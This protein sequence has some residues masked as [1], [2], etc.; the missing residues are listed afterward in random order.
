MKIGVLALQGAVAEHIRMLGLAGAEGVVIK[1]TEQL[2]ELD[3]LIIPGGESTTIGKLMRT[4][5]FI[6]AIREFS[7]RRKPVF[8][9]CAGMILVAKELSGQEEAH[10]GLMD[11][12]VARN[13][14][15]R[16]RESFETDLAVKGME[17]TVRAVFIR[18][19]LI[20]S[21]GGNVDV[22]SV[23]QDQI[24]A[25]RQEHLLAASFHPELTDDYG[26]HSYFLDMVRQYR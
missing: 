1:R 9:T 14:F 21:V 2:E 10:L 11:I 17:N 12:R 19:P 8:G 3:G 13:A 20:E 26:F 7:A 24:V 16:Q 6:E 4:Y 18:A 25:A 15:G 23:Y 22:L 5:G